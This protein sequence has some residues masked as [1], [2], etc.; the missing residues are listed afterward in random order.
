MEKRRMVPPANLLPEASASVG[1]TNGLALV[2]DISAAGGD[3]WGSSLSFP[4][5]VQQKLDPTALHV[6]SVFKYSGLI[7]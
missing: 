1:L 2:G 3:V 7:E 4:Q 5:E 6:E